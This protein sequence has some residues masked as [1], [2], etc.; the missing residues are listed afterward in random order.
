[1]GDHNTTN[2]L[3]IA[4][5]RKQIRQ[6]AIDFKRQRVQTLGAV[7]RDRRHPV[8]VLFVKKTGRLLHPCSFSCSAVY[9]NTDYRSTPARRRCL[10]SLPSPRRPT[11]Q[12][13]GPAPSWGNA[14]SCV[15]DNARR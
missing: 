9:G 7:E 14:C 11:D 10:R 12:P 13:P 3:L 4:K 15:C 8:L 5:C 1:A 6:L 2:V